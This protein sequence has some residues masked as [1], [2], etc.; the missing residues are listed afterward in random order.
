MQHIWT[1]ENWEKNI[2]LDD[3][4]HRT[5]LRLKFDKGVDIEVRKACKEFAA[6]MRREYFFPIRVP[7]YLKNQKKLKCMDGSFAYGTFFETISYKV[8]PYIRI[9]VGDY[10]DRC[11]S[12]GKE[13]AMIAILLT[14]SHE[15]THYFQ[16]INDLK[17][18][19]I[20]KERQA[21]MYSNYVL[22]EFFESKNQGHRTQ[23]IWTIWDWEK[24]INLDDD[25]HRT[26]LIFRFDREVDTEVHRACKE[27]A[28]Y[29]RREYFFPV[30][31]SVSFKNQKKVKS[32]D[33]NLLSSTF[34]EPI[35]YKEKSY[36]YIAVGDYDDLRLKYGKESALGAIL[37]RVS[38]E[39]TFYFQWIN[40]LKLTPIGRKR[41]ATMYSRYI[42]DEYSEIKEHL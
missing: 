10:N 19:P 34:F 7:V 9:A 40:G 13:S 24:N 8:E 11:I 38:Y 32:K 36:I 15:L 2:D 20:G 21:T 27:F 1:L 37:L 18:T 26:G 22:D 31:I 12:W 25:N 17:L 4:N 14:I 3:K 39:L 5:G 35:S 28:A 6:F 33:G 30:R 29:I 16:W 41:Q 23:H 42:M